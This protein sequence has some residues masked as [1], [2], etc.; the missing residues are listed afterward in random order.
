MT[1]TSEP[2]ARIVPAV[3]LVEHVAAEV[4]AYVE[5]RPDPWTGLDALR[6]LRDSAARCA[7][8]A[9]AEGDPGGIAARHV[10][11]FRAA[12]V[13]MTAGRSDYFGPSVS[14]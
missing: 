10:A 5:E 7:A 1:I 13:V 4:A 9:L 14:S 8:R 2:P 6:S 11:Y 3:E 12:E